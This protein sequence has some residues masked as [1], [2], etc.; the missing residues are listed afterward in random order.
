MTSPLV[1]AAWLKSNISAPDLRIIDASWFPS[2]IA[3]ANAGRAAYERGHI[4]GAV[5]FD[6]DDICAEES[7]LPHMMPDSVKFSSRVRKL[8]VGDGNRI[9]VYDS[10][11]FIASARVWWMFRVMGHE[12]VV[13][14][15]GGLRA[16]EAE[17]G[18]LED[19]PP[20]VTGGR[21]FTPRVQAH[22]IKSREQVR[23]ASSGA[24]LPILDARPAGRFNGTE[25][26]PR[27][28]LPSGHIPGSV[29][30]PSAKLVAPDGRMADEIQLKK[31]FDD[32]RAGPVVATCGSGV[33]AAVLALGLAQLGNWEAAL[34][35][36]SWTE[37]ASDKDNPVET[38]T[39]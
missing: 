35:D 3:S 34:Y 22:L 38:S 32:Y 13:V 17:G 26:E 27:A 28:G 5:Y 7:D 9:V 2:W 39:A 30:I 29:N 12:D 14:L 21:H 20:I 6:I 1:S 10:N 15:D 11:D 8:G 24:T 23:E 16:W 31:L 33:S 4:P 36:G 37:W 25:E 19:L 18:D